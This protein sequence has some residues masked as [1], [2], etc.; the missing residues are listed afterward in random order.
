MAPGRNA[1]TYHHS[2]VLGWW[3]LTKTRVAGGSGRAVSATP[4]S[5]AGPV[6]MF[7]PSSLSMK[8]GL[9]MPGC[10]GSIDADAADAAGAAA[11]EVAGAA[12]VAVV[13]GAAPD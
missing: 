5:S 13:G 8:P 12:L 7:E 6:R 9:S 3:P 2:D 11:A 1:V 4:L 10:G